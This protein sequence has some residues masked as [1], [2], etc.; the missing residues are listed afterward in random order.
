ML[1]K[2]IAIQLHT[3]PT[4]LVMPNI[5]QGTETQ[6]LFYSK[7]QILNMPAGNKYQKKYPHRVEPTKLKGNKPVQSLFFSKR[8]DFKY[9]GR[10]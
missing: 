5:N 3:L 4:C 9:S 2:E 8:R 1:A 6:S 10:K 7:E